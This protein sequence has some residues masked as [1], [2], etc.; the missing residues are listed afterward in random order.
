M[1]PECISFIMSADH[2]HN[3]RAPRRRQPKKTQAHAQNTPVKHTCPRSGGVMEC[4]LKRT[5]NCL[6][7][8]EVFVAGA[9][10]SHD[11]RTHR[12]GNY[13]D[14]CLSCCESYFESCRDHK[15]KNLSTM[16]VSEAAHQGMRLDGTASAASRG[17]KKWARGKDRGRVCG[18]YAFP[19]TRPCPL[20]NKCTTIANKRD[21][22][23]VHRRVSWGPKRNCWKE[24]SNDLVT[25]ARA[26]AT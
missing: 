5:R 26:Y 7:C 14:N 20:N 11:T 3:E 25:N 24:K 22:T 16:D 21:E 12:K 17:N 18:G 23:I 4:T 6:P 10:F 2:D 13:H 1:P 15:N 8:K 19:D 9:S